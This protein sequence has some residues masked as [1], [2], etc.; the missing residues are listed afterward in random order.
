MVKQ[1]DLQYKRN[2]LNAAVQ[3]TASKSESNRALIIQALT[4]NP[5]LIQNL[6]TAKDTVVLKKLLQAISSQSATILDVGIAG[7][8]MRFLTA[9]LSITKGEWR[10]TG[11]Q[12]MM[13]RPIGILVEALKQLGADINYEGPEG[14]PPLII[15]G[16]SLEGGSISLDGSVSSQYITALLLVAPLLN[17]GLQIELKG[18]VVSKPY[19]TMTISMMRYFGVDVQWVRNKISVPAGVYSP[20]DITIGSDW[21]AASY[22]Y[23]F[24]ALSEQA[25]IMLMGLKKNS[26]QGDAIVAEIY[27]KFWC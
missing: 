17:N 4:D 8:T 13:E 12:R 22:W 6:A 25:S 21:S 23:G 20:K 27:K 7:T 19:V 16:K 1:L 9:Y 10:L 2:H 14:Y 11:E 18:E 26:L 3:L 24:A 5:F 15:N